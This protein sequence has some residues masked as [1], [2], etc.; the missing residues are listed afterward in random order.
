MDKLEQTV[1]ALNQTYLQRYPAEAVATIAGMRIADVTELLTSQSMNEA[2]TIWQQLPTE[3]ASAELNRL[4]D[5]LCKQLLLRA[6]AVRIA[7]S[8]VRLDEADR[9]RI[10]LFSDPLKQR[11][12]SELAQYPED[13]AGSVMDVR[14]VS[15]RES[16]SVRGAL[17]RI[18]KRKP[19]FTRQL[20]IIDTADRLLG[21][22]DIHDL[23]L[24]DGKEALLSIAKP[25]PTAVLPTAHRDEVVT[26]LDMHKLSDLPVVDLEGRLVGV[27]HYDALVSAVR[28]ETSADI[29]TMVGVSRDERALSP[30]NF[31]VRKRLPWLQIN[32]ITAFIA[33]AVVG[34]FED[35]IAKFTALAVLL[36][37][38][39]GQSGNTGAQALAVT[40]R[41]LALREIGTSQWR[42]VVYK[43]MMAGLI[44]GLAVS[45]VTSLGVFVWSHSAG[46]ALVIGLSMIIAMVAAAL[47]GVII[48]IILSTMGQDPAQS[49]SIILTTITDVIGFFSFLGIATLLSGML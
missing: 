22:V 2:I 47:S 15:L 21:M 34:L 48:P 25:I 5:E 27:I 33:A 40:M 43:E 3:I 31:V 41:S 7:R 18:R 12:L 38:V 10:L 30:I 6:D 36:P 29:L 11:E 32:L 1:Q 44:N 20:F 19:E 4:P 37:V 16:M 13:S 46:L 39:A 8:L 35:L 23:A 49:S 42:L 9:Q 24:T 26:E 17:Q 45:L 14:F 28:E